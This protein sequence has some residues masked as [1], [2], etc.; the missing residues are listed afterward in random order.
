MLLPEAFQELRKGPEDPGAS[1]AQP[2]RVE[3][4][5]C[6]RGAFAALRWAAQVLRRSPCPAVCTGAQHLVDCHPTAARQC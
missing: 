4:G 5:L 6:H 2:K 3:E 1:R